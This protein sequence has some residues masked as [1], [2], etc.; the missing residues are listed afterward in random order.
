MREIILIVHD[1][2]SAHNVGSILRTA[3]GFG[4]QHVYLTGY[5]PY[6]ETFN[7]N[8]LPHISKKLTAQIHK[9]ALEAEN[10][11]KW[12]HH[13]DIH[14]LIDRLKN[15][16]FTIIGL[17]QSSDAVTLPNLR[18]PSRCTLILGREVE[19]LED[20]L[21]KKCDALVEIQ[22]YGKKES[23]NVV[24]AAAVALYSLRET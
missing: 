3:E 12:S 5:T 2:R 21:Q 1:I 11:V 10:L 14:H 13:P 4:V 19:G 6:P 20:K 18:P 16:G 8:R 9:T 22:M 15:D 17:E 7:D 24:Q 23:F